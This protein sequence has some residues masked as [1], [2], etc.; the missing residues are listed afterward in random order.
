MRFGLRCFPESRILVGL[1][2]SFAMCATVA[3]G[4]GLI[5]ARF[6]ER[7][8][9][10]DNG[11]A[12]SLDLATGISTDLNRNGIADDGC[13]RDSA[14]LARVR[15]GWQ[16]W[17]SEPDTSWVTASYSHG[18]GV[19]LHYTVPRG[20]RQVVLTYVDLEGLPWGSR[21]L[22]PAAGVHQYRWVPRDR[23]HNLRSSGRGTIHLAVDQRN[24]SV[25]IAWNW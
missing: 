19:N 17:I 15:S 13:E 10:N 14:M 7:D 9:C 24:Y 4:T 12:D 18:M 21:D 6:L 20:T 1:A 5:K 11:I 22:E 16:Q 8:D 2:V 3:S 23:H 25:P